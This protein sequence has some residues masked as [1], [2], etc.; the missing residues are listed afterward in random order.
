M[1]AIVAID[2]NWGIGRSNSLL[3]SIPEDM[4]FFRSKTLGKTVILGRKNLESFPGGKPLPKRR[5]IV[6]STTLKAGEGYE[7]ARSISEAQALLAN[8]P[9]DDVYVIGG[10]EIY[11]Q[12]LPYCSKAFVTKMHA[13]LGPDCYFPNL[14]AMPEWAETERSEAFNHEGIT[15][16]F[17]TYERK[18]E[19]K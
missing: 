4:K 5:N 14:D 6:I 13:D 1:I 19:T 9:A 10:A 17:T 18:A 2:E 16:E 12:L 7:I 3:L 15:Y 11:R 8:T